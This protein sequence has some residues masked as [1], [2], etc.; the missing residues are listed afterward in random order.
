MDMEFLI[1]VCAAVLGGF[2]IGWL[3]YPVAHP[4]EPEDNDF[5]QDCDDDWK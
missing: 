2:Y 4:Y 5:F 1:A 3:I